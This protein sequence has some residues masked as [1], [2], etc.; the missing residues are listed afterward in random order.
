MKGSFVVMLNIGKALM[1]IFYQVNVL[2]HLTLIRS[3]KD[4]QSQ[5][6]DNSLSWETLLGKKTQHNFFIIDSTKY[7]VKMKIFHQ[8]E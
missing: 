7:N 1:L 3:L 6:R 4:K 8:E 2:L 5:K